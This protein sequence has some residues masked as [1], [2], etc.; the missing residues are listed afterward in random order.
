MHLLDDALQ[1]LSTNRLAQAGFERR[2]ASKHG[3]DDELVCAVVDLLCIARFTP[4]LAHASARMVRHDHQ[5]C[6]SADERD[7]VRCT[8]DAV[9]SGLANA[10]FARRRTTLLHACVQVRCPCPCSA[11]WQRTSSE[12]MH[13]CTG[14]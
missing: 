10:S 12:T 7:P 14:L 6:A 13:K 1:G 8:A 4:R 9:L 2:L 11:R 5:P 3:A